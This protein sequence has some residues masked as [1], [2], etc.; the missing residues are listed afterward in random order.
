MKKW[1]VRDGEFQA[2][3]R[4]RVDAKNRIGIPKDGRMPAA[5]S[6]QVFIN[7][8]GQIVLDPQIS[9]PAAEVWLYRNPRSLRAVRKGLSEANAGALKKR[10]TFSRHAKDPD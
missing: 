8:L 6:Y 1:P 5:D 3:A 4:V 9:I 7:K 2:V 10:G